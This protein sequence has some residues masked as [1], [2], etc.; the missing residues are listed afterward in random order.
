MV[1]KIKRGKSGN[2]YKG[3]KDKPGSSLLIVVVPTLNEFAKAYPI[4]NLVCVWELEEGEDIASFTSFFS[5]S[6][7]VALG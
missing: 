7:I 3:Y 5:I 6:Y 1:G 2:N 4:V